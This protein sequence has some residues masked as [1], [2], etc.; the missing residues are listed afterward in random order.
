MVLAKSK[1]LAVKINNGFVFPGGVYLIALKGM[2][3]IVAVA[4]RVCAFSCATFSRIRPL[5]SLNPAITVVA[6]KSI[7]LSAALTN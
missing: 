6:G 2:L 1:F 7:S 5:A 4:A 3:F